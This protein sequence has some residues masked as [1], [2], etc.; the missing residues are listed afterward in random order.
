MVPHLDYCSVVYSDLS[1]QLSAQLQR[2][3]NSG[4]RYIYGLRRQEHIAPFRR[5]LNWIRNTTRTNYFAALTMYTLISMRESPFL[6]SFFKPYKSGKPARGPRKDL[7]T[8]SSVTTD[9]G[10]NSFQVKYAHFWNSIPPCTRDLHSFSKFKKGIRQY[11]YR[12]DDTDL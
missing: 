10:L 7:D 12:S 11:L 3:S 8:H 2:L 9:W 6:L 1:N 4:I 5:R